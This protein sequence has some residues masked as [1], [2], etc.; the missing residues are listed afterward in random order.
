MIFNKKQTFKQIEA[1]QNN[2]KNEYNRALTWEA[3]RLEL[4]YNSEHKAWILTKILFFCVVLLCVAIICALPLKT[5]EPFVI[6]V[7]KSTGMSTILKIANTQEI[8]VDEMMNKYWLSQYVLSRETYDWR[9]LNQEYVKVRELS[10]PNIFDVYASQFGQQKDSLEMKLKDNYRIDVKLKSIV[11]NSDS[12]ATIR[13]SKTTVNNQT[14]D[15]Q[16]ENSFTATIGF[17]Y[18][19][20]FK[21][22][23]ERRI[24]NPFGFKVTSYRIDPEIVGLK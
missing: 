20:D 17:E 14:G 11:I 2:Q 19:P 6:Q 4:I 3:S 12:I 23:E 18:F 10:M 1:E 13:F 24:I 9:T 15:V 16:G 5:V 21:V 22:T 8:P 7:D